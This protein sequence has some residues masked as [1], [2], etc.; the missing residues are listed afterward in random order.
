MVV[1][2]TGKLPG[3]VGGWLGRLMGCGL[4]GGSDGPDAACTE[5]TGTKRKKA[6]TKISSAIVLP[7]NAETLC[8]LLIVQTYLLNRIV[9]R[10]AVITMRGSRPFT[11]QDWGVMQWLRAKCL[12]RM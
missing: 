10:H 2:V 5:A 8:L 12:A 7:Q 1:D 4:S 6:K 11:C 9:G 3:E